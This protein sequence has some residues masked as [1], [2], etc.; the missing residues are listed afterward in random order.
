LGLGTVDVVLQHLEIE[1][2]RGEQAERDQHRDARNAD[3]HLELLELLLG[4]ADFATAHRCGPPKWSARVRAAAAAG[5]AARSPPARAARRR[6]ARPRSP[7]RERHRR[8]RGARAA[9]PPG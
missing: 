6:A 4:V 1:E 7:S 2:A 3:A 5:A 8:P 9:P